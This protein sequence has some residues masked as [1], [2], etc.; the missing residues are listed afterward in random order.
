[1][2]FLT[3]LIVGVAFER[4][5]Q[6][7]P[8]VMVLFTVSSRPSNFVLSHSSQSD[9]LD[10]M[11]SDILCFFSVVSEMASCENPF[12]AN[13]DFKRISVHKKQHVAS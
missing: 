3:L 11:L 12:L 9:V 1:M 7:L 2:C 5:C 13:Q 6:S 8:N 4:S 10:E